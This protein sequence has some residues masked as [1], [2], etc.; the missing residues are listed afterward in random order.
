VEDFLRRVDDKDTRTQLL[1]MLACAHSGRRAVNWPAVATSTPSEAL[2]AAAMLAGGGAFPGC[3]EDGL[4]AVFQ[5]K[6]LPLGH[7]WGAF[8]GLQGVLAA[9]GRTTELRGVVDSAVAAGMA[10]ASQLYLLDA[11]AGVPVEREANTVAARLTRE[12]NEKT[13]PF[14]LWLL[15]EWHARN[16]NQ[17]ET[18]A[19]RAALAARAASTQDPSTTRLADV[20]GAR[21]MVLQGDTTA[22]ITRLRAALSTGRR[23]ALEWDIGE[24][25]APDR[26]LLAKLLLARRQPADAMSVAMIFDH[27]APALF[28][29]FLPASLALRR[30][31]A[32]ELNQ[33]SDARRFEQRLAA[34]GQRDVLTLGSPLSVNAE[35]R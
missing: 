27:P 31:A 5:N 11:L 8:L 9:E 23:E 1:S 19:M 33:K 22:A 18:E 14:T 20:L 6:S 16:G 13:R 10:L 32:L 30:H 28:L 3:A 12:L 26:L 4:R 25:L 34:L 2:R 7:R 21:L 35:A 15:G 24:A 17:A 29:P